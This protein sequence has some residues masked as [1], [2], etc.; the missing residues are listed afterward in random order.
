MRI[1]SGKYKGRNI[2]GFNIV[3]T[4]PTM[5]RIRESLFAMIQQKIKGSICLDL[6]AGSGALGFEAL[7]EGARTCYF[8]DKNPKVIHILKQNRQK[9][10]IEEPTSFLQMDF[11]QAL[12][13]LK[14]Q[15]LSFDVIFLDPP[16]DDHLIMPSLDE[17]I[18]LEL[19]K[20]GGL[21]VCEYEKEVF[22]SS[23]ELLKE[24]RYGDKWIRI[25]K[26]N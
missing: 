17:I 2:D 4:R 6:F 7:S 20:Q 8:V 12:K 25:Y 10:Q 24:K 19:L 21:V 5:D 22:H 1:I 14:N 18:R 15:N 9:L 3:G 16:Y 26:K 11:R 23:L 13:Q